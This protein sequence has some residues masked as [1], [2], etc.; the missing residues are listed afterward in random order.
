MPHFTVPL[1]RGRPREPAFLHRVSPGST[2][3]EAVWLCA[4]ETSPK[5]ELWPTTGSMYQNRMIS[6]P[7]AM[8]SSPGFIL[9][10]SLS[11]TWH[12]PMW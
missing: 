7:R 12:I 3:N 4:A 9:M 1:T 6:R 5:I 8:N 11:R 2:L 10:T